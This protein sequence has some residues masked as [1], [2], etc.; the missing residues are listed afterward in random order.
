MLVKVYASLIHL[1]YKMHLYLAYF[2]IAE[3]YFVNSFVQLF[4]ILTSLIVL[5]DLAGALML[6]HIVNFLY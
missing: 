3:K 6:F 1:V 5:T 4:Q 2:F